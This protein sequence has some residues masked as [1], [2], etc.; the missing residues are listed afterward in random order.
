MM[1]WADYYHSKQVM[2][3]YVARQAYPLLKAGIRINPG[4][5]NATL[6]GALY[7]PC[8]PGSR[9]GTAPLARWSSTAR[10]SSMSRSPSMRSSR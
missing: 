3:A 10:L 5:S 8:A 2:C 4:Y 6:G 9:F 7:D 1:A